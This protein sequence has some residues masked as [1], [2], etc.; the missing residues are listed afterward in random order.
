MTTA[1]RRR[2]AGT[3]V[4]DERTTMLIAGRQIVLCRDHWFWWAT[5]R[6]REGRTIT[7]AHPTADPA[8]AARRIARHHGDLESTRTPQ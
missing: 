1:P 6:F 2:R 4:A 5:G 8:G 3:K 7:A